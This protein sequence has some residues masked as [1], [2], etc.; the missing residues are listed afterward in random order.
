MWKEI[1]SVTPPYQFDRVLERLS[2]DPLNAVSLEQREVRLPLRNQAKEPSIVTV[3]AA[4]TVDAPEF[5]V[6]GTDDQELMMEEV[7]RIFGWKESLQPVL[8]HFSKTSL[9]K[10]FEEHAG[11]PLVL[12]FQLYHCLM[13]CI[14]H[15]QL[16][17]SF[18]FTLTERFVHTFGELKDGVWFYPLPETIAKLDYAD[19]RD[20]QFSMRKSEYAIDTSRMI[21]EGILNLD[22]LASLTDEEIMQKLVKIRGIGPW[23][24]QNVLL[25]GLGRPNLF[26]MADIGLQNAIKRHFGLTDKPTKDEMLEMSREWQPYLSYASLYLW[27]S[28]E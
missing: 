27:R 18:A 23:T 17:L 28:I 16:N 11:T 25:F 26:P 19:L 2:L 12:D 4:G 7:K 13:K 15:Q 6:S 21:A 22:E 24:V 20:L 14:I 8:D 9:S 3:R 1:V 5:V 10:L